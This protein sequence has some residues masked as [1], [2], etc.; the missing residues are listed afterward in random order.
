M[1]SEAE[2]I[3]LDC[4]TAEMEGLFRVWLAVK[5]MELGRYLVTH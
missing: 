5:R 1:L 2:T 4:D 3:G